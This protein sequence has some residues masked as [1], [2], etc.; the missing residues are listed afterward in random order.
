MRLFILFVLIGLPGL[1]ADKP[2]ELPCSVR[3]EL[4]E[5]KLAV[6]QAR[7][8]SLTAFVDLLKTE[9]GLQYSFLEVQGNEALKP[10]QAALGKGTAACGDGFVM[11]GNTLQCVKQE[12]PP[13][14]SD[15]AASAP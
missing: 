4:L 14:P 1:A 6:L 10:F 2:K 13:T 3:V 8:G 12:Q 11:D 7:L 5:A 15:P 9:K